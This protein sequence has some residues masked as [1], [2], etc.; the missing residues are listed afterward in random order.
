MAGGTYGAVA[1]SPGFQPDPLL[2]SGV[3]GNELPARGFRRRCRGYVSAQPSLVALFLDGGSSCSFVP[4]R[5]LQQVVS[6]LLDNASDAAPGQRIEL[7][8]SANAHAWRIE[9]SDRGTST[10]QGADFGHQPGSTK[11]FGMGIGLFLGRAILERLGGT[12]EFER[13][14]TGTTAIL[15]LPTTTAA[16]VAPERIPA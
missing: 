13:G 10:S 15:T 4:R 14:P 5:S 6:S 16:R 1:L 9:V 2:L 7:R 12:L 3:A 11:P 8:A